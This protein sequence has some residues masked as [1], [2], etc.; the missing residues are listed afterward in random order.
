[1]ANKYKSALGQKGS[2]KSPSGIEN[3]EHHDHS[4]S[5]KVSNIVP[6]AIEVIT[7]DTAEHATNPGQLVRFTNT[8]ATVAFV[9]I[10]EAG[11]S[12]TPTIANALAVEPNSSIMVP[13]PCLVNQKS[14]A[15]KASAAT[16]QA[17]VF[18]M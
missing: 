4:W 2:A 13:M 12:P 5:R 9:W 3:S 7:T 11:T 14:P 15:Y 6:G 1:M 18:E 8:A 10:G 16:V 17:V